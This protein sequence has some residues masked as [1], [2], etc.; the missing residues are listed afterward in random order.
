MPEPAPPTAVTITLTPD[1]L[2]EAARIHFRQSMST[3]SRLFSLAMLGLIMAAGCAGVLHVSEMEIS[4]PLLVL[5][6]IACPL[7]ATLLA[8]STHKTA[9]LKTYRQ[10]KSLQRP[11]TLSW[12]DAGLQTKSEDGD[13][14]VRWSDVRKV[15]QSAG[16]MLFYESEYLFRLLPLRILTPEQKD[17]L[18]RTLAA[19]GV[20]TR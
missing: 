8:Y 11:Y 19:H 13:W 2:L 3:P 9:T 20:K 4:I 7:A 14:R 6:A 18:E 5:V 10:Q 1:D 17:D 15:R 12:S 16:M